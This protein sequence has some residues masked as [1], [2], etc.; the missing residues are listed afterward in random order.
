[1]KAK[2]RALITLSFL[3]VAFI[4]IYALIPGGKSAPSGG[5]QKSS[6]E[7]ILITDIPVS[8]LLALAITNN[9]GS[10]GILNSPDGIRAVSDT[11]AQFDAAQMRAFI[12]IACHLK[13]IRVLDILPEAGDIA[14]SIARF[15]LI[16]TGGREYHF[17]FLRKS[18]VGEDYLLF[19][20]EHQSVFVVSGSNA[21]WFLSNA[22]D[23]PE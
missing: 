11:D 16:L 14:N 5:G 23:F 22:G 7:T 13:G 20:E 1:M 15:S 21:E 18:P 9:H 4:F 3:C 19:S 8:E 6:D 10:F 17:A 12:Y 2:V